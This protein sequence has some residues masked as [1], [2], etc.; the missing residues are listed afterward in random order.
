MEERCCTAL[1][2]GEVPRNSS[3]RPESRRGCQLFDRDG[4]GLRHV[5]KECSRCEGVE[6]GNQK[7]RGMA[8]VSSAA[9]QLQAGL[10]GLN[11]SNYIMKR[12]TN[13][14]KDHNA[15]Q[16]S[17]RNGSLRADRCGDPTRTGKG[18]R[19]GRA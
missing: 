9:G 6:S 19:I 10:I 4:R 5:S 7:Y 14:D 3:P 15:A 1:G 13:N 17:A 2:E 11:V 12:R 8:E 16:E 18:Q